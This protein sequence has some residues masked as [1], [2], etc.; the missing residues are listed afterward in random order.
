MKRALNTNKDIF[1]SNPKKTIGLFI[2]LVFILLFVFFEIM[3]RIIFSTENQ[4]SKYEIKRPNKGYFEIKNDGRAFGLVP[5]YDGRF[6]SS[7]FN[8][9]VKTNDFG[10]RDNR[11]NDFIAKSNKK[12]I[13]VMGDSFSF[14]YGVE[15]DEMYSTRLEKMLKKEGYDYLVFSTGY[16]DG[17]SPGQYELYLK[18]YFNLFQPDIVIVGF[19]MQ[20]DLLDQGIIKTFR[21]GN[22]EIIKQELEGQKVINGYLI[23]TQQKGRNADWFLNIKTW[24]YLNIATCRELINLKNHAIAK[25]FKSEESSG[26]LPYFFLDGEPKKTIYYIKNVCNLLLI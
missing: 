16:D 6:I 18:K 3:L 13:M 9:N 22:S 24:L 1:E 15:F 17:F 25:I 4:C 2:V 20:N 8:F 23:E 19:F 12:K 26:S 14:G 10:I 11:K 5:N 21:D 7:G